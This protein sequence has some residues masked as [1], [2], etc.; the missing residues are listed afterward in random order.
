MDSAHAAGLVVA[1]YHFAKPDLGNAAADEA[2]YFARATRDYLK[3]GCLRPVL[4]LEV[5]GS[6]GKTELSNWV[7]E[8]VSTF[9]SETGIEPIFYTYSSFAKDSLDSSLAK[10]DL[11]IAHYTYDPATQPD[12]AFWGNWLF[13]QYS[14]KGLVQGI[15]GDVDLNIFNGSEDRFR[16]ILADCNPSTSTA[17]PPSTPVDVML[18]IDSSG[19]MRDND[20]LN[21]RLDAARAYLTS[22]LAGD[23]VGVVDFDSTARLV[24]PLQQL[25]D[26]KSNLI[27]VIN[28]IDSDGGTD[29]GAGVKQGCDALTASTSNVKKGAILLTDGDGYF[30]EQHNCFIANKWPIYTFGI[31]TANDVLL[32][33]IASTTGGEF[34][35]LP[36]SNLLCEFQRVRAKIAG[37]EPNF[38]LPLHLEPGETKTPS[39]TLR[40]N[41]AQATF[42]A[43]WEG[44]DIV[45]T[46]TTPS[47]RVIDRNTDAQDVVHDKGA[48][49]E[50]Y[51]ITNPEPGEKLI[52]LLQMSRLAVKM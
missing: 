26:N 2:R 14:D 3:K 50:V 6:L 18:I 45:M 4:D 39:A 31:G 24:G 7:H 35:R 27:N 12:T 17:P 28:T 30:N 13:W 5:V 44:S 33:R 46:L 11:W 15:S 43:S 41:Q 20:P 22:S 10:Y 8:W 1:P 32:D 51:T 38:C 52:S 49:F 25:P 40:A 34:S 19:S 9:E 37:T 29:I 42:S 48:A 21:K 36:I 16:E 23:A 47:G